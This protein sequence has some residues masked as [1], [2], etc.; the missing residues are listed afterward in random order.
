M[1]VVTDPRIGI[2]F[3]AATNEDVLYV[4]RASDLI[5]WE[6]G[7]RTRVL[8]ETLSGQLTARLQ[9]YGYLA[10]SAARYPKSIVEIGGLTAP[11]F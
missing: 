3:G 9:V 4:L 8:P 11:T 6:S 7:V 10:C 1:P 2:T 5:L